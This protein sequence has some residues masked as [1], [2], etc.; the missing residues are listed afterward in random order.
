MI[1]KF[2][3]RNVLTH[4]TNTAGK[5]ICLKMLQYANAKRSQRFNARMLLNCK[6][7]LNVHMH[8]NMHLNLAGRCRCHIE[9]VMLDGGVGNGR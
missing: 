6:R 3:Q 8:N 7:G 4:C 1:D 5:S 9:G 2:S